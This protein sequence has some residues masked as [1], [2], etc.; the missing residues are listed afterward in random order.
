MVL[1][2]QGGE[3]GVIP[4]IKKNIDVNHPQRERDDDEG[5]TPG[6]PSGPPRTS[7]GGSWPM[8]EE[9]AGAGELWSDLGIGCAEP[10]QNAG[11]GRENRF[12]ILAGPGEASRIFRFFRS[13][14]CLRTS[15]LRKLSID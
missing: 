12:G 6:P 9:A 3:E 14:S 5:A 10:R 13:F 1:V 15:H 11:D 2:L 7:T 4:L 8:Q